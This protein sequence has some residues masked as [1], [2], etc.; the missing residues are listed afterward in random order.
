MRRLFATFALLAPLA[1]IGADTA[2]EQARTLFE[3]DWQWRLQHQPEYATGIGE[4]RYDATLSDLSPDGLRAANAHERRM[5]DAARAIERAELTGQDRLSYDLF[6][7]DK[8]RKL[9]AAAI[10]PYDPQPLTAQDGLHIRLPQIVAQM[11]FATEADYRNYLA[12]I[13]ALPAHVDGLVEQMREGMRTGW[14][15]PKVSMRALPALLRAMRA[16]LVDGS[17]GAPFRRIPAAIPK[18]TRDQLSAAGP[19]ALRTKAAPALEKLETFVRDEYLPAARES[20]GAS[21]LPDGAAWYA[22]AVRNATTTELTP[23]EIHALGLQEVARIRTAMGGAIARTGFRGSVAEF[24]KFA[25]SDPR[26]FYTNPELL[27]ARYRRTIARASVR[28]PALFDSVPAEPLVVRPMQQAGAAQQ[29]AAYYEAGTPQRS[30]ALV[31]NT[32]LLHT[33]PLWM[34]ETLALHE[35]LPGHHLQ[36]ARAHEI[37]GLPAFRRFGWNVAYGEGW[38]LYAETLGPQLGFFRDPFSAF[39]HLNDELFRAARLVVDT[40]IHAFGWSRQQA[41][42][43]LNANTANAP[44]DNEA[45]VDRYI[46]RPGQA[47]GYKIGQ[48]R[49]QALRDEARTA[50]GLRFD[51]R[52]FHSAVL[53]N[54][55]LPLAMLE[56]EVKRWMAAEGGA[57]HAAPA[58]QAP[59]AV[60]RPDKP[61]DSAPPGKPPADARPDQPPADA[62]PGQ[63]PAN[64]RPDMPP[65][66]A[67]TEKPAPAGGA[68]GS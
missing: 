55:P 40:G 33:R 53:D 1:A 3:R 26:L 18:Q 21:S 64:A 13:D 8:E 66:H 24:L 28:L 49:L 19:A 61:P 34:I 63:P 2:T 37:D 45:E 16:E 44:S 9:A 46:A 39:G 20:I 25:R 7:D 31:V 36:V 59:A 4:H 29:A 14:V 41:L 42:D 50:L 43:Y 60:A 54:G 32:S 38:A 65:A 52:R 27:L 67:R 35:A 11:P 68:P 5:L 47:L 48:L 62:R 15:A 30:A 51:Q 22:Q 56:R 6:I 12:R 17:L 57:A 23:A 58:A 10:Y